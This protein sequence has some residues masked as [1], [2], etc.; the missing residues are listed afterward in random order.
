MSIYTAFI[1][2]LFV[3]MYGIPLTIYLTSTVAISAGEAQTAQDPIITFTIL[4]QTLSLTFWKIIGTIISI[5]GMLT[6]IVGWATLYNK[7]QKVDLVTSGIYRYS[8]HPQYLG[9]ILISLGW[10]VHWPTLLT[11][12]MLP[13]LIYFYYRLTEKEEEELIGEFKDLTK[14]EKYRNNT[15]RFL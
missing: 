11:L 15:P 10:F 6:I 4:G 8:R 13:I 5:L 1:I 14:Y 2:S 3:E 12:G 9:I 7:R